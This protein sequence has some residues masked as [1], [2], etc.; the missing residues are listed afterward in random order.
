MTEQWF[1]DAETAVRHDA[2]AWYGAPVEWFR[3]VADY[4]GDVAFAAALGDRPLAPAGHSHAVEPV[5]LEEGV[6]RQNASGSWQSWLFGSGGG[7]SWKSMR[8]GGDLGV[9]SLAE[10]AP[11][12]AHAVV[13]EWRGHEHTVH[14]REGLVLFTAWDET[15]D[16]L[17]GSDALEQAI[18]KRFRE[19]AVGST[20]GITGYVGDDPELSGLVEQLEQTSIAPKIVRVI[21]HPQ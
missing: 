19:L 18:D 12:G 14:V 8:Q 6:Y 13:V 21:R 16:C 11:E 10:V 5:P 17:G 9:V 15:S 4:H 3:A 2:A 7:A 1:A 20:Q